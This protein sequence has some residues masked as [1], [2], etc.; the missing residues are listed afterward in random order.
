MINSCSKGLPCVLSNVQEV[1]EVKFFILKTSEQHQTAHCSA[2]SLPECALRA[3]VEALCI[4]TTSVSALDSCLAA[5]ITPL[6]IFLQ[7]VWRSIICHLS[8]RAKAAAL[9]MRL[10]LTCECHPSACADTFT[11]KHLH[12]RLCY[13][14]AE[15]CRC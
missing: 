6:T 13:C 4:L 7:S 15:C 10:C 11:F 1:K 5:K 14:C 12:E 3:Q 9:F 8:T 2:A